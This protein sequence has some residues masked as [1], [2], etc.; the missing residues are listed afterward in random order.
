MKTTGSL[1][2]Q[3]LVVSP[4]ANPLGTI[5]HLLFSKL[6]R[7]YTYREM[8]ISVKRKILYSL[9][10]ALLLI[11]AASGI[12]VV[13]LSTNYKTIIR[14]RIPGIL[15]KATDSLYCISYKDVEINLSGHTITLTGVKLWPDPKQVK[16]RIAQN[17]RVPPTLSTVSIP[18]LQAYGLNW[19]GIIT[20]KTIAC[21]SVIVHKL[22]W[23]LDSDPRRKKGK[24]KD[25][26]PKKPF[27]ERIMA[28]HVHVL[29]PDVTFSFTGPRTNFQCFMKGGNVSLTDWIYNNDQDQDTSVF[30][31]SR[32]GEVR[33]DNFVFLK[34]AGR[35]TIH[36]PLLNFSSSPNSVSLEEVK[37]KKMVKHDVETG[38]ER[39]IYD[40]D[41]PA[42]NLVGFNWKKLIN[43]NTLQL[44]EVKATQPGISIKQVSSSAPSNRMGSYPHQLLLQVGLNTN[45]K[46][47]NITR[48]HIKYTEVIEKGEDAVIEFTDINGRL[49]NVTNIDSVIARKKNCVIAFHGKYMGKSDVSTTFHFYLGDTT[50]RF[51]MDG[52]IKNIDGDDVI[53]QAQAFTL[54]GVTS[55]HLNKMD[56]HIEGD[57][58]YA[59]GVFT[60]LYKDLKISLLKF[61]SKYRKGKK[62]P[63][64]FL[65]S[66]LVLY[67]ANPLPGT[68]PRTVTTTFARDPEKGFINAL[69]KNIYR[70]AKKTAVRNEGFINITDEKESVKGEKPKKK[71]L[72]KRIFGKKD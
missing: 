1:L 59:K 31:F 18:L 14:E 16:A 52:T 30:L 64:S 13:W 38:E 32:K 67:P 33:F 17:R 57:E 70:A 21:D 35:Y 10:S 7:F 5:I 60:V 61:K 12:F 49:T 28:A 47:I 9:L 29:D 54:V 39:E 25:E 58:T 4:A 41:F 68:E 34:K 46:T 26:T 36:K 15:A 63:L 69:W 72:I 23:L 3:V 42:I 45:L 71:G 20:N 37:I 11:I 24:S 6:A 48:G 65:G 22:K 62:G 8:A 44:S 27:L 56:I 19:S 51:S 2:M 43:N 40:L 50:G 55:F 53:K 66:A